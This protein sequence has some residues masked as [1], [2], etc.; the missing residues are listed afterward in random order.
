MRAVFGSFVAAVLLAAVSPAQGIAERLQLDDGRWPADAEGRARV[1]DLRVTAWMLLALLGDGSTLTEGPFREPLQ[2][3]YRWLLAQRDATGRFALRTDPGWLHDQ[4]LATYAFAEAV[5]KSAAADAI[6]DL[7]ASTEV[8]T[9]SLDRA[10]PAAGIE[11]RLWSRCVVLALRQGD[12]ARLHVAATGLEAVLRSLAPPS[13]AGV[14][15][16]E[17]AAAELLR[18][19]ARAPGV[20]ADAVQGSRLPHWPDDELAD[21]LHTF[22]AL[23]LAWRGSAE[24]YHAA[25]KR[26]ERVVR[27]QRREGAARGTWPAVGAFGAEHGEVGATAVQILILE[28]YYRYGKLAL[29]ADGV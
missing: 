25:Q 3:G 19:L 21:P 17:R 14:G 16:R 13:L 28:C 6:P 12:D 22:Y 4:A 27:A 11:T 2:A 15:A 1:A 8:L 23:V 20:E 5:T 26:T 18:S 29:F 24:H 9:S 10:R 7:L